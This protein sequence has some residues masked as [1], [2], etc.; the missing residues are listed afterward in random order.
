MGSGDQISRKIAKL[1][2]HLS[3]LIFS[4]VHLLSWIAR[5]AANV[6]FSRHAD[7]PLTACGTERLSPDA[8]FLAC[9]DPQG[10]LRLLDVGTGA[11]VLERRKYGQALIRR[12]VS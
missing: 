6:E 10:T 11:T 8:R 1:I 9:V 2:F 4:S 5:H 12:H 3:A 7:V